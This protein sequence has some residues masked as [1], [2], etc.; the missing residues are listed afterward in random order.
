MC[1]E[2]TGA[3]SSSSANAI[4]YTRSPGPGLV[5]RSRFCARD[6]HGEGTPGTA[7]ECLTATTDRHD[8]PHHQQ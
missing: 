3:R 5:S 2:R 4:A 1:V 7:D 8:R 6:R